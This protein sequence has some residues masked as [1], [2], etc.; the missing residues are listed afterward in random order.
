M[1]PSAFPSV[2]LAPV[3][4]PHVVLFILLATVMHAVTGMS[5]AQSVWNENVRGSLRGF[6]R[7]LGKATIRPQGLNAESLRRTAIPSAIPMSAIVNPIFSIPSTY[8][9]GGAG[10]RTIVLEDFNGDGKLDLA[11][12]NHCADSNCTSGSVGIL[13]GNGDG[14]YQP[15][16]SYN[17]G[18]Y[19]TQTLVAADLNGDGKLDLA[20]ANP[21]N[22]SAC[23]NGSVTVLLGNGDGTFGAAVSYPSGGDAS[24]V[25]A[26]D[27]NADGKVDLVVTNYETN[28]VG[29]LLGNGNGSF[30]PVVEYASG[31]DQASSVTIADLNADGRLDLAV[32][33]YLGGN[34]SILLGN[35][36]GTFQSAVSYL[37]GGSLASAVV[38]ADFNHDN[39][40]DLAVANVCNDINNCTGGLLG[41]LLGNG[42]GT[43][44]PAVTYPTGQSSYSVTAADFN[45]DGNPDLAVSA[46]GLTL[47]VGVGD[48]TFQPGPI[49]DTG[50]VESFFALP[51][52]V[53]GDG[54]KD[55]IMSNDCASDCSSGS[56]V[57]LIG[58][59][60]GTFQAPA[61]FSSNAATTLAPTAADFN[62]DGL[63]DIALAGRCSDPNCTA[64]SQDTVAILLGTANGTF[65]PATSYNSGGNVAG[66]AA[67]GDFNGDGKQD[68]VVANQCVSLLDCSHG[69]LGV[70]LGNGDGTFQPAV[71][72]PIGGHSAAAL[73]VGDFDGD[74]KLDVAVV[75]QPN[76]CLDGSIGSVNILL[77]NGDGSFR[78]S[79]AY[80]TGDPDSSAVVAGDFNGDGKLDLAVANANCILASMAEEPVCMTGSVGV[81]L[82]NGDGS[83]KAAVRYSTVDVLAFTLTTGDFNGDGK[84]DL[85]VGNTNCEENNTS[86]GVN[87]SIAVLLGKG[88]GTFATAVTYPSGDSL[89]PAVGSA[90]FDSDAIAAS[91]LNGDGKVDLVLS[92]RS[93]L[94]G[95][96][97]GTFQAA[98][99]YNATGANGISEVVADFNGDGKP[100][101]VVADGLNVTLLQNISSSFQ[102]TT[103]T[104]LTSSRNPA[105][106]HHGVT[107]AAT[108]TATSPGA[109]GGSITF[110]DDGRALASVPV[111]KGKAKFLTSS[112]D[113]GVHSI[114]ASY[115][116]DQTFQ[117]STS[118]E[119][120][121]V[122][123]AETRTRLASSQNPSQRGQAVTFTATVAANSGETPAGKITF[124]DFSTVLATV[125]LSGGQATFTASRLRRGLHVIRADYG[126]NTIDRRSFAVVVQRVK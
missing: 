88:D 41:V 91:D 97:D 117:P 101:L 7:G 116:G 70:L 82:G 126:G 90:P 23:T 100:D 81:L 58:N 33:N 39:R 18:G 1:K 28:N 89:W 59:G 106:F 42:D 125:E 62:H 114:T 83:F 102:Q 75:S 52:D 5:P 118:P 47:L 68:I 78:P 24:F 71:T 2:R 99:S 67:T 50:G 96:G 21:C 115:S 6:R 44:K 20:L 86:C 25:E 113:A 120:K 103:S 94:L 56:V 61:N 15:A 76:C 35:G 55:L 48:G 65:G 72:Y 10:A 8:G 105:E 26:A 11:V 4:F 111:A 22:D 32:T 14:T 53:N 27:L 17:S 45:G 60:N 74:G 13:L 38:V 66:S 85:A 93:V 40:P 92:D 54:K 77:G 3:V 29:V 12:T 19:F 69:V 9:S 37:S 123:R 98:Q 63:P 84:L 31:G 79:V 109:L 119:L 112:L 46:V 49:Y 36:N 73:T 122:I 87:S 124:R 108:V 16:V 43:F 110:S 34:V 57:T 64:T 51:G 80:P 121:Q 107:F 30:Q 95:N 104:A